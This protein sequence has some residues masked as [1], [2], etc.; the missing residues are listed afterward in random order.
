MPAVT[1]RPFRPN[2]EKNGTVIRGQ[3]HKSPNCELAALDGNWVI[4]ASVPE[5]PNQQN[6]KIH[7]IGLCRPGDNEVACGFEEVERVIR[8]Q[9]F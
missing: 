2:P 6:L 3:T 9:E 5:L 8:L 4:Y 7:Q 1:G